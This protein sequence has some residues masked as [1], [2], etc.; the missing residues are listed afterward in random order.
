MLRFLVRL[1]FAH[2]DCCC[3]V[4]KRLVIIYDR[5]P[6]VLYPLPALPVTPSSA[7]VKAAATATL[8]SAAMKA[9]PCE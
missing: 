2:S 3:W 8:K 4:Q 6:F 7:A 1:F 9:R 5:Q